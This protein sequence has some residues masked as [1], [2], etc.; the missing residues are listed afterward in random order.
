VRRVRAAAVF[1]TSLVLSLILE[2]QG[3]PGD[4]AFA[5]Q[6]YTADPNRPSVVK[7]VAIDDSAYLHLFGKQ[8]PMDPV[9][10][11]EIIR[12]IATARPAAIGVDIESASPAY[13]SLPD[14]VNGVPIVWARDT[15]CG[16]EGAELASCP[17]RQRLPQRAA[18]HDY[19][20]PLRAGFAEL[21]EDGDGSTRRYSR[22]FGTSPGDLPTFSTAV[23]TTIG[24]E[25]QPEPSTSTRLIR[26]HPIPAAEKAIT[27]EWVLGTV[28]R[29]GFDR[30]N[31]LRGRIV[32]LGGTFTEGRDVRR[33]AVG[34]MAGVNVLAQVIETELDGGGPPSPG[35][36][37]Y[38]LIQ[39][40]TGSAM[41]WIF[42]GGTRGRAILFSLALCV[43]VTPV[44]SWLL[45]GTWT[46]WVYFLPGV[47]VWLLSQLFDVLKGHGGRPA[48]AT[49]QAAVGAGAPAGASAQADRPFPAAEPTGVAGETTAAAVPVSPAGSP[50]FAPSSDAVPAPPAGASETPISAPGH[51]SPGVAAEAPPNADTGGA[52]AADKGNEAPVAAAPV[53]AG[54][55]APDVSSNELAGAV[56][57]AGGGELFMAVPPFPPA[58]SSEPLSPT[59][60]AAGARPLEATDGIEAAPSP[61]G[62]PE[63]GAA[64]IEPVTGFADTGGGG[65]LFMA[66]PPFPPT[67]LPEPDRPTVPAAEMR[68]RDEPG[69]AAAATGEPGA[70]SNDRDTVAEPGSDRTMFIAVPPLPP[71]VPPEPAPRDNGEGGGEMPGVAASPSETPKSSG[72]RGRRAKPARNRKRS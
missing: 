59:D 58:V 16:V 27:A 56:G 33:T 45:F 50:P 46:L 37:T 64:P 61:T 14:S 70:S 9:K 55:S 68:P 2:R 34:D 39:L 51:P 3:A 10:I 21:P 12:A 8:S 71:S 31:V 30:S 17:P 35:F 36:W 32:L 42:R 41:A 62:S 6:A 60:P 20:R 43:A 48:P 7:V 49:V 44:V 66:V 52:A 40:L 18:G 11:V 13:A 26:F 28:S 22:F 72:K 69:G 57:T 23:V 4:V 15:R 19:P 63:P 25:V 47:S 65:E 1:A 53:G 67:A 29:G 5:L 54:E 24:R 38:F